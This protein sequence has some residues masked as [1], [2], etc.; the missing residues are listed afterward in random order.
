[1]FKNTNTKNEIGEIRSKVVL[2][3][4][5]ND[6]ESH[7]ILFLAKKAEITTINS[8]Q[9]HGAKLSLEKDLDS[10]LADLHKKEI[11]IV[12]TPGIEK[13]E[14]LRHRGMD[15]KIIDHHTYNNLDRLTD[16]TTGN[17]K[18]SSLEQFL[19]LAEIY[20]DEMQTWG[21]DP[22]TVRGIGI[23]D[24]RYVEGLREAKYSKEEINKV[25]DLQR[26]ITNEIRPEFGKLLKLAEKDWKNR[27][28]W[29]NYLIIKS[30]HGG[31]MR[32][33]ISEVSIINDMDTIPMIISTG[34][35]EKISVQNVNPE[36][37]DLLK[38][39]IK[40]SDTYTFGSGHCWGVDNKNQKT[41]VTLKQV[42][43]VLKNNKK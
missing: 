3:C 33:A 42:L 29:N 34:D 18:P 31:D 9:P 11:W 21:L 2:L 1:M 39:N 30:E 35:G 43:E 7:M 19:T 23:M 32:S 14:E 40:G 8:E 24:S 20:D 26:E 41:K 37:V 16:P 5:D 36:V 6:S 28:E 13:E 4:P 12:E 17:K 22:K 38:T 10:K 25:F 15:V 27:I